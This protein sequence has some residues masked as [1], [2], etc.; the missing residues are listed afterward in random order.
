MNDHVSQVI[1]QYLILQE[2]RPGGETAGEVRVVGAKRSPLDIDS[3]HQE[4][5]RFFKLALF[6]RSVAGVAGQEKRRP[7]ALLS[8]CQMEHEIKHNQTQ[9]RSINDGTGLL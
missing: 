7:I 4:V 8:R 3:S 9:P 2:V 6:G 5:V 1:F